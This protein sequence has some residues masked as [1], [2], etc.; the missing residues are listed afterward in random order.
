MNF[1]YPEILYAL[2]LLIIPLIIHLVRWKKF[3]TRLFTN[4]DLLQELEI[5]SRKSRKLKEW[6]VLLLRLAAFA[7]LIFAFAQWFKP[8]QAELQ[9]VNHNTTYIFLD[10]SLSMTAMQGKT[11]LWQMYLQ[12]FSK[13]L[14]KE[15]IYTLLTNDKVYEN[16]TG[17]NLIKTIY[18]LPFSN[19]AVRHRD[20]IQ[21][22]NL[23][24]RKSLSKKSQIIY[25]SDLQNVYNE[26]FSDSLFHI[27]SEYYFLTKQIENLPDISLDSLWLVEKNNENYRLK[28]QLS[29]TNAALNTSVSIIQDKEVL[30]RSTI[31]FKDELKKIIEIT[32]PLKQDIEAVV[33]INDKGFL[34]DNRL[35]FTLH[36]PEKINILLVGEHLPDFLDKIYT[37][38]EFNVQKVQPE[39]INY[40]ELNNYDFIVLYHIKEPG[41]LSVSALN[42]FIDQYGNLLII[43]PDNRPASLQQILSSL[44][45]STQISEDTT[46]VF[47]NKIHY[48][49]PFFQGVFLKKVYN[50]AYPFVHKHYRLSRQGEWLYALNDR[51]AFATVFRQKGNIYLINNSLDETNTN[52]V[53]APSLVV[54]LFY[55]M[56]ITGNKP[57]QLYYVNANNNNC[58]IKAKLGQDEVLTLENYKEKFIP[59]QTNRY[60]NIELNCQNKPTYAGIYEVFSDKQKV[61]SVAF[62]DDR[63]EKLLQFI[64]LPGS[65]RLKSID[66]LENFV[67]EQQQ[68][69]KEKPWWK[70][71]LALSLLLLI[72]EMLIIKYWK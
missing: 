35:F 59:H 47:L 61:S 13:S 42:Q 72:F 11:N 62:N 60:N 50:F 46:R 6:I 39:K 44:R 29:A 40:S 21:K 51:S 64:K 43:P 28:L 23:L 19:R 10:N 7:S 24:S 52:F 5:K 1:K 25:A 55:Q 56:A 69:H 33:R 22:I 18:D 48:E 70:Y 27:D 41:L 4:L 71:L 36:Q 12:E 38:D 65:K 17:K 67:N 54:P 37:K 3:K 45:I 34:F 9:N 49:H 68:F 53:Q 20:I 2:F 14:P 57:Q 31:D 8:S 58:R 66:N 15:K 63:K 32:L 16:I 26:Q 30:W